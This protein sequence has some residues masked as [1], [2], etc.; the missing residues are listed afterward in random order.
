MSSSEGWHP[1]PTGR[2]SHRWWDGESWTERVFDHGHVAEDPAPVIVPNGQKLH[3]GV[4]HAALRASTDW[5]GRCRRCTVPLTGAY[6]AA[7]PQQE[8][9]PAVLIRAAQVSFE[10]ALADVDRATAAG[11]DLLAL[12]RVDT[13]IAYG[14]ILRAIVTSSA[15]S[16]AGRAAGEPL[17]LSALI[18]VH[19][20]ALRLHARL[21]AYVDPTAFEITLL[22]RLA[23]MYAPEGLD[24]IPTRVDELVAFCASRV[25][26]IEAECGGVN[27]AAAHY[28]SA[29]EWTP[30]HVALARLGYEFEIKRTVNTGPFAPGER[31]RIEAAAVL[32]VD[33]NGRP[34][35]IKKAYYR[36][37]AKHHPDRL[38]E[39]PA[40]LRL[41]AEERMKEINAAYQLLTA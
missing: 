18:E 36:E 41:A 11:D 17:T 7:K 26:W 32:G 6:I 5:A 31:G 1:D 40:H 8:L 25:E 13:A 28:A 16:K 38:G 2:Y 35:A 33:A 15:S 34:A 21:V 29:Y 4:C 30:L 19:L 12:R 27:Q 20:R 39:A 22:H 37:A 24:E 3:C 14:T 9:K 23:A 10:D